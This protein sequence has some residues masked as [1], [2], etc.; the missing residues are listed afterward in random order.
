MLKLKL[1]KY[2]LADD[3]CMKTWTETKPDSEGLDSEMHYA[4]FYNAGSCNV[5]FFKFSPM[6]IPYFEEQLMSPKGISEGD[7]CYMLF[8]DKNKLL[9]V[10]RK[11]FWKIKRSDFITSENVYVPKR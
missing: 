3:Y 4:T 10:F 9:Y 8:D 2:Y 6:S 7:E 1:K 5:D 11:E